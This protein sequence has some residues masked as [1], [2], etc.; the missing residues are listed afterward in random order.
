MLQQIQKPGVPKHPVFSNNGSLLYSINKYIA[1]ILKTY[2]LMLKTKMTSGLHSSLQRPLLAGAP[3]GSILR[4][5]LFLVYI[6]DLPNGLKSNANL[7]AANT[8]LF[9]IVKVK[10][11][12]A[13][14]LNNDLSLISKWAFSWEMVINPDTNKPA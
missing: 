2:E 12:N 7:F 13:D 11:E 8:S 9:T 14:V 3:Q 10:Q 5:L 6:N 1:N 4:P